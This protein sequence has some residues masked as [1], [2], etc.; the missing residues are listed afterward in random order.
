VLLLH[1]LLHF[2]YYRELHRIIKQNKFYFLNIYFII[3]SCIYFLG[4]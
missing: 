2:G 1:F 3:L 4:N